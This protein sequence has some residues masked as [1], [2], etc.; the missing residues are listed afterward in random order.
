MDDRSKLLVAEDAL[1]R[2]LRLGCDGVQ[3]IAKE[4]LRR[5]GPVSMT[6][7]PSDGSRIA[8]DAPGSIPSLGDT[9]RATQG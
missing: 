2:I 4:A 5:I 3:S 7:S 9:Q 1:Q 8:L 6:N